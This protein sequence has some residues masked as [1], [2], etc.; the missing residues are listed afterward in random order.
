MCQAQCKIKLA[1]LVPSHLN[2]VSQCSHLVI[3]TNSPSYAPPPQPE[4]VGIDLDMNIGR[5]D[6]LWGCL[7]FTGLKQLNNRGQGLN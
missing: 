5:G 4:I 3:T 7:L 1:E 2:Q 6:F